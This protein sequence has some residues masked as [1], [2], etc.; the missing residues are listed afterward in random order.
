MLTIGPQE[1]IRVG[2]VV[3]CQPTPPQPSSSTKPNAFDI[4]KRRSIRAPVVKL[5]RLCRG[6]VRHVFGPLKKAA[7]FEISGDAG[8]PESV[9]DHS[10][11][12]ACGL[13][14]AF[15]HGPRLDPVQR[16]LG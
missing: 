15:Y 14:P 5:R 4:I 12:Q 9:I 11:L 1:Q 10:G 6:V 7:I 13:R 8:A 16:P 2:P 3:E